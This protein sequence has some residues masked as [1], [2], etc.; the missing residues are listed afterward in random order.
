M[1]NTVKRL[2]ALLLCLL[3][4][5]PLAASCA[6]NSGNDSATTTAGGTVEETTE[7][8]IYDPGLPDF[9]FEN[10]NFTI[11]DK[12]VS[13]YN[14]WGETSIWTE[15]QNGDAVNDAIYSRNSY[16][17]ETYG[18]VIVEYQ[19]GSVT[20][21][22]QKSV[23]AADGAYDV[24][25]PAFGDCG[26]LAASG[27]FLDL[28]SL[29][30][31]D[32]S[33]SWWDQRST[34]DLTIANKLFFVGSD[35]STLNNDATWCTMFNKEM[36]ADYT[37]A[38]PYDLVAS[39]EWT[40]ENYYSLYYNVSHDVDGDGK[41][42]TDDTYANLTQNENYNA[43]YIGSG[44]RLVE[45]DSDDLP[46]ISLGSNETSVDIIQI[47]ADIMCDETFSLN[48][49][50]KAASLGYHLWT[51]QMFEESRGLFWITNLQIVIRLRDL[52]TTMG[53]V[54]VP[55]YS[56]DQ[57]V[58]SNVVWTVGSYV[59]VPMSIVETERVGVILEALAAK[60]MQL[61]RPAY[62]DI[63]LNGKYLRD[64]ESIEMLD[65]IID[66]RV[67]DLGLA[68]GFSGLD[69]IVQTLASKN[70]A[71]G[72]MSTMESKS[73]SIQSAIDKVVTKFEENT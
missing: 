10:A 43:M 29:N 56:S 18:I 28:Y 36:I 34:N 17:E 70:N 68:Y 9:N 65:I 23:A 53:I 4:A 47:I 7:A 22:I 38:N 71:G 69:G 64:E 20:G 30:Y 66:E 73:K 1:S 21:D 44:E 61:L 12:G 59:A 40:Y 49:H 57:E 35:I 67:Y 42:S 62:Y 45:K 46:V 51:T 72:L 19:S 16:I 8:D 54:P 33:R 39:N 3:I 27:Q 14:E 24:V 58:Y 41:M 2:T 32:L 25:M 50:T 6:E 60:S 63:A 37:V 52:E 26:T 5:A 13:T 31:I 11:L 55:K 15:K 48:Y